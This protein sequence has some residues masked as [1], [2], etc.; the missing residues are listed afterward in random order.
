[1]WSRSVA[2]FL[3]FALTLGFLSAPEAFA[4]SPAI[5]SFVT[6]LYVSLLGHQPDPQGLATWTNVVASNCNAPGLVAVTRGFLGS[7]EF[8]DRPLTLADLVAALVGALFGR[9][10]TADEIAGG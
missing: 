7:A 1:M 6:G 5:E 8:T 9:A 4:Q 2:A 3:G 10:P